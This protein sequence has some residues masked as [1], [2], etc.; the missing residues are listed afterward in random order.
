MPALS[1]SP[2]VDAR[3]ESAS[4]GPADGEAADA[5]SAVPGG[6]L[7]VLQRVKEPR[8]R[9]GRRFSLA[10]ILLLAVTATLNWGAVVHRGRRM[11]RRCPGIRAGAAGPVTRGTE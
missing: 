6:L 7:E 4:P 11:G 3:V 2:V 5:A 10:A 8:K 1:S 9:R